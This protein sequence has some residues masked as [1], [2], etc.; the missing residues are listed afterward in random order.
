[1]FRRFSLKNK[2]KNI[3]WCYP[4]KKVFLHHSTALWIKYLSFSFEKAVYYAMDSARYFYD[5]T[6]EW[7]GGGGPGDPFASPAY[8]KRPIN[9]LC[10]C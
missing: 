2:I 9:C 4:A 1:V 6:V 3:F 8:G 7:N 5:G 10:I